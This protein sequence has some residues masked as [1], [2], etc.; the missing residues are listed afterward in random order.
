MAK[1]KGMMILVDTKNVSPDRKKRVT[2]GVEP[3]NE[4]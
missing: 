4:T 2:L 1:S 3:D